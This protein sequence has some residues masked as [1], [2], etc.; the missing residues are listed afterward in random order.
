MLHCSGKGRH[1]T[2]IFD[3]NGSQAQDDQIVDA[4]MF[5]NYRHNRLLAPDTTPAQWAGIFGQAAVDKMEPVLIEQLIC[6]IEAQGWW[7][8]VTHGDYYNG[9]CRVHRGDE[10]YYD[11]GIAGRMYVQAKPRAEAA[12]RGFLSIQYENATRTRT[13]ARNMKLKA[14]KEQISN[15]VVRKPQGSGYLFAIKGSKEFVDMQIERLLE[16]YPGMAYGTHVTRQDD[17]SATVRTYAAD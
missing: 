14:M 9:E 11:V 10:R 4:L 8:R 16:E 1:M 2:Q 5:A 13:A 6:E 3:F 7:F 12:V 15:N 17:N